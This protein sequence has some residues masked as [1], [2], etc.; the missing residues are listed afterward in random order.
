VIAS[1]IEQARTAGPEV[2]VNPPSAEL[3]MATR[4]G[5][6]AQAA[7]EGI[8][9]EAS[10]AAAFER[11]HAA[12]GER[13]G[14]LERIKREY[15]RVR[16][17][18]AA[19]EAA[20]AMGGAEERDISEMR[21]VHAF[22][23]LNA[24]VKAL[25][26]AI[27]GRIGGAMT[28]AQARTTELSLTDFLT[29]RIAMIDR[30]L[31]RALKA[32]YT[33]RIQNL[34]ARFKPKRAP[35]GVVK[36]RI[37]SDAQDVVTRVAGY[38]KM[39]GLEVQSRM[40]QIESE[41]AAGGLDAEAESAL[42]IEQHELSTFGAIDE[43]S[44]AELDAAQ[45][46]LQNTIATGR[47]AW[48][49]SEE[50]RLADMRAKAAEIV[51]VL[52]P[53]TAPGVA[54][55]NRNV[56]LN[57]LK[58]YARNHTSF[59]QILGRLFPKA[60]FVSDW[61]S[62]AI[63]QDSADMDYVRQTQQRLVDA[64]GTALGTKSTVRI[65]DALGKM[66]KQ[67]IPVPGGKASQREAIQYLF[68]WGQPQVRERMLNQGWTAAHI[69]A[70]QEA[71]RDP[72]SQ[73]LMAFFQQEYEAIYQKA[74][75][76]YQ[77]LYGM[78][79]PR[80]EGTYAPMR[81][82]GAGGPADISPTGVAISSGVTPSAIK[83]RVAHSALLRQVDSLAVFS[84]HLA[85]MSHWIHFAEFIRE[86]RGVLN[87]ATAKL[88]LEQAIGQQGMSDLQKQLDSITRNGV[89]RASDVSGINQFIT[90]IT[91]GVAVGSMAF[92][93]HS[94]AVQGDSA[95]RWMAAI[96][97]QRWGNVLLAHR[98]LAAIPKAWHS[99]TVQRRVQQGTN[100]AVRLAM[101]RNNLTPSLL[102]KAVDIGFWPINIL[103]GAATT[104]SSAIVY[105]DS[106]QQ[107]M[108]EEQALRKMDEAVARF[109]QPITVTSKTQALVNAGP[110]MKMLLMFM[111]D[112]MLK[113]SI[114]MDGM[115]DIGRGRIEQGIR[116]IIAVEL[117]SLTSQLILNTWAHYVTGDDE[118]DED[119]WLFKNFWRAAIVAPVQ[120]FF[121]LGNIAEG[122]TRA[123]FGEKW[124]KPDTAIGRFVGDVVKTASH[125]ED[126]LLA[127]P[128]D[129][130][131][132]K[133]VGNLIKVGG[134][135]AGS[136]WAA[137]GAAVQRGVAG[138][139][140]AQEKLED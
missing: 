84:E 86:T 105:A 40:K 33:E 22:A 96:P 11:M 138:Y 80:I 102:L 106:I 132:Q 75:P 73:A 122:I 78:N 5:K 74:N 44:A 2:T 3:M 71:T 120:G 121:V 14:L 104:V 125:W 35:S 76:V 136:G 26:S 90:H 34:L 123:A 134:T 6:A 37:G 55:K 130:D 52:P 4:R 31:E 100:P 25:P 126:L 133:E 19:A 17:E 112:P 32:E 95:L 59:V 61:E 48:G 41:L 87:N 49:A 115:L 62:T 27:R 118:D 7:A 139:Q 85:Q 30:E 65:G 77:K 94:A 29:K 12:P 129:P 131:F 135:I 21:R 51:D 57:W 8:S 91:K 54:Q 107:G 99:D 10:V 108:S 23:E 20:A 66:D 46:S 109:S 88:A 16:A 68:A 28:L 45:A 140:A 42:L 67:T 137:A 43:M 128:S 117:W 119:G 58:N 39:S 103:D 64:I 63:R 97:M 36:G 38:V 70:L 92:N 83:G 127:D 110:S 82:H 113:T 18:N 56:V 15:F 81:Y 60:S 124:W 69:V 72:I 50:A 111:A 9:R 79:L 13:L 93:L 1:T 24:L 47:A 116:K 98:W 114:A 53:A 101:E 89:T